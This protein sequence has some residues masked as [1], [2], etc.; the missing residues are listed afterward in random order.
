MKHSSMMQFTAVVVGL[1]FAGL[2]SMP[3][4]LGAEAASVVGGAGQKCKV[5]TQ[6][7]AC[8]NAT[9]QTCP[10]WMSYVPCNADSN[11]SKT[12]KDIG[13]ACDTAAGTGKCASQH[14]Y[15]CS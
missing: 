11:S 3:H 10:V 6:A 9:G 15:P 14:D 13:E 4:R 12:C 1:L 2:A 8:T 5:G 7:S